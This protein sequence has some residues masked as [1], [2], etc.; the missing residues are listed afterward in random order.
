MRKKYILCSNCFQNHGLKL[1]AEKIGDNNNSSCLICKSKKG[2]KITNKS[3]LKLM[4]VFFKIGA[5]D[6]RTNTFQPKY[7][8]SV[9]NKIHH[10]R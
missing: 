2:K 7:K 3:L 8:I 10:F 5:I 4:Q 9:K 1:E 6:Y